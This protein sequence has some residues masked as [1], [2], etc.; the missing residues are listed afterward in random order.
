MKRSIVRFG[1]SAALLAGGC[2]TAPEFAPAPPGV[3]Q[4]AQSIQE[5]WA[6]RDVPH[7]RDVRAFTVTDGS[8]DCTT[9]GITRRVSATYDGNVAYCEKEKTIVFGGESYDYLQRM[10]S[11]EGLPAEEVDA[12]VV[13]HEYGHHVISWV[14]YVAA[15]L[16]DIELR[17]DCLA[18]VAFAETNPHLQPTA[19]TLFR[20]LGGDPDHGTGEQRAAAFTEGFNNPEQA[21]G[22]LLPPP[23]AEMP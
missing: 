21:C 6:A 22:V 3:Q 12:T 9:D 4:T 13:A 8:V 19:V 16:V 5:Y 14:G 11:A 2:S 20:A 18:G 7:V 1:L 17:A 23:I 15:T 10:A